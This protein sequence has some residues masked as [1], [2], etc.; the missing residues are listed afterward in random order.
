MRTSSGR[1]SRCSMVPWR[2]PEVAESAISAGVVEVMMPTLGSRPARGPTS[3]VDPVVNVLTAPVG[4][5]SEGLE[6]ARGDLAVGPGA[7]GRAGRGE[8]RA[9]HRRG[10]G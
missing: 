10:L 4:I 8:D 9:T 7:F 6:Q 2:K 5:R 3:T 1:R